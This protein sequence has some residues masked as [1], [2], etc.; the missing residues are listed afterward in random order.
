MKNGKIDTNP[1]LILSSYNYELPQELIAQRPSESRDRSRLMVLH[2]DGGAV[3]H[4]LFENIIEYINAGDC[5]VINR[6]KVIPARLFGRKETGGRV[7][8]L[9]LSPPA[10]PSTGDTRLAALLRPSLAVGKK[11]IFP[12]NLTAV[13]ADKTATGESVLSI[14]GADAHETLM[15]HGLMPLPPYIKRKT[16][17]Q[18]LLCGEDKQRYQ[19]V[20]A[21][22][23]GSIAAPTAGLHFTDGLL[24]RIRD[25]GVDI[26]H[27]VLHVG[28]GTFKP[29]TS[30]N[31]Q[32]HRMLPER[33][34]VP[35][36]TISA[37]RACRARGGRVFSVGTTS[38]RT[39]ET[40]FAAPLENDA[41]EAVSGE[42]SIFI[43]PGHRFNAV[44]GLITN[45]HLPHSTPL[46]MASAF[47]GRAAIL[48]AY[49]EAIKEKYRFYSY[50]D[51]MLIL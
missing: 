51:A 9:F 40:V 18:Q 37:I 3:E 41:A 44:D 15:A 32:S 13:V 1:D 6:T 19:T 7:E 47:A 45:F 2:R 22:R 30:D 17:C 43:H 12:G 8:A 34:E 35:R 27:V 33:Y 14:S 36:Q 10:T 5:L 42:T 4:R 31:V 25:K 39:L 38:T 23:A 24:E 16:G 48:A 28:W 20:Y 29:V 46:L 50:G 11:I 21:D 26:V 49:A